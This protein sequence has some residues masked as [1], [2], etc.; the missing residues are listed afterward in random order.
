MGPRIYVGW[1]IH[2]GRDYTV[3]V[4]FTAPDGSEILKVIT[5]EKLK[6]ITYDKNFR[7]ALGNHL[8]EGVY[9]Y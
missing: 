7:W 3:P 6:S 8:N 4:K 5:Y 1:C 9:Y 2:N